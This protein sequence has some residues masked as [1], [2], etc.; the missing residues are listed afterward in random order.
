MPA[1]KLL[2]SSCGEQCF[3]T[4]PHLLPPLLPFSPWTLLCQSYRGSEW[5]WSSLN[6]CSEITLG[7]FRLQL[8]TAVRVG[9]VF[10]LDT[11]FHPRQPPINLSS[12]LFIR[13]HNRHLATITTT[14]SVLHFPR[15][16]ASSA[17]PANHQPSTSYHNSPRNSD[18]DESVVIQYLSAV[19]M[20]N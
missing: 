15:R 9:V 5:A 2:S 11:L 8:S 16:S 18:A 20:V 6:A 13:P 14:S 10:N 1:F 19:H 7:G 17:E 12:L 4:S 3:S